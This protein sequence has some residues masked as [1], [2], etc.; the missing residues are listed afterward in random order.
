MI[1]VQIFWLMKI[2]AKYCLDPEPDL[3][4]SR[5]PGAEP[6]TIITVPQNCPE[7]DKKIIKLTEDIFY[8]L[9]VLQAF[10]FQACKRA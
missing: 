4:Q 1:F 7:M 5:N 10:G 8:S 9:A 2:C 3:L 6:H